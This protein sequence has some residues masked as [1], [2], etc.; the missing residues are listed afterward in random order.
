MGSIYVGKPP[1]GITRLIVPDEPQN[2]ISYTEV[3]QIPSIVKS[4][5]GGFRIITFIAELMGN[6]VKIE[7]KGSDP[8]SESGML[9]AM[10]LI[11]TIGGKPTANC[12]I[13]SQDNR[14]FVPSISFK[15]AVYSIKMKTLNPS[16]PKWEEYN[17]RIEISFLTISQMLID[18]IPDDA[19]IIMSGLL[20]ISLQITPWD[21]SNNNVKKETNETI[22]GIFNQ[23][24]GFPGS[25]VFLH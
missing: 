20:P 1:S 22:N 8:N 13:F 16:A 25:S 7:I 21:S 19:R 18:I 5:L 9:D 14:N 24:D 15:N 4:E 23:F 12:V 3:P 17:F 2:E 6:A 10:V 11:K